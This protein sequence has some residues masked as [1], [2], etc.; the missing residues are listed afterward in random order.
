VYRL[1]LF[2]ILFL[3]SVNQLLAFQG[4]EDSLKNILPETQGKY[5]L[6]IL[7]ELGTELREISGREAMIYS[8]EADSLATK[9]GDLS[10]RSR[11]LENMGWIY[12]RRGDFKKAFDYSKN[13]Y[14]LAD[15]VGNQI[16]AARVLNNLGALYYEQHNYSKSID[17]FKKAYELSENSKDLATQIRSLNNVAYNYSKLRELDSALFFASKAIQINIQAGSP[18][19]TI[20]SNRVIGDVYFERGQL[21]SAEAFFSRSME[22]AKKQRIKSSQASLTHRLGN[23][24]FL[25]GKLKES[26]EVLLE[27]IEISKE[28]N[29]L[30]ELAKCNR[31][32][33]QVYEKEKNL[34]MAYYHQSLSIALNDSLVNQTNRDRLALLQGMFQD[35]LEKSELDLLKA[36]NENQAYRLETSRK[37]TFVFGIVAFLIAAM[38]VRMYFLNKHVKVKNADLEY[39]KR[40][41][42]SQNYELE[43]KSRQLQVINETKNKVFSIIGHDLRGPVGQLRSVLSLFLSGDLERE[44]FDALLKVLKKDI[45]SVDFTLNNTLKW[46]MTQMEGFQVVPQVFSF[47]EVVDSSLKLLDPF[48]KEKNL[49]LFNTMHEQMEVYADPDSIEVVVRNILNNAVKYSNV[50]DS[51][52]IFSE[53][54]QNWLYWYVLDQGVGMSEDQIKNILGD[55]YSI[56]KSNP[57]TRKEKGS[58]LG[59]QLSKE[60]VRMNGGE[61]SVESH[62]GDGTKFCL[63]IPRHPSIDKLEIS[64]DQEIFR[65]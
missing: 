19:L 14:L 26:K 1:I 7:N 56:T 65:A 36:Q 24:F 51:V 47:K 27:G 15:S 58:G 33:A 23:T 30:D 44:E 48:F 31:Y 54:D 62:L 8:L 13:A 59:L 5:R 4:K 2:H 11:A 18:Y 60:L 50:G 20:F 57:G 52:T 40:K 22:M 53:S 42:E 16:Q 9:L 10:A 6:G 45:D 21:D 63:K 61:I 29:F 43:V 49:T 64:S 3:F 41:I 39:Q 38:A 35:N 32:L 34:A 28:N 12:Y 17:Q 25:Q 37:Y 46:S 55:S